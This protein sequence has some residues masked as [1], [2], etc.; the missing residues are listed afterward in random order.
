MLVR[1]FHGYVNNFVVRG[2]HMIIQIEPALESSGQIKP[3]FAYTAPPGKAAVEPADQILP[4][5]PLGSAHI[6][7]K[8]FRATDRSLERHKS[9]RALAFRGHD[10]FLSTLNLV[11]AI[12]LSDEQSGANRGISL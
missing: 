12:R 1:V 9:W 3:L 7:G 11:N 8:T 6:P 10:E 4:T 2:K 5:I